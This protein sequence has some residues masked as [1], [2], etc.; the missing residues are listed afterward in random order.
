MFCGDNSNDYIEQKIR[1]STTNKIK[2]GYYRLSTERKVVRFVYGE[3]HITL[4]VSI[5]IRRL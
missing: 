4:A 2:V 1:G 5:F 3:K